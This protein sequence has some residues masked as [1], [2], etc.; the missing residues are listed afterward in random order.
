M[1]SA[2][3]LLTLNI[4]GIPIVHRDLPQRVE[5][6]G[7]ELKA[8]GYDIV[9]LQEA[10]RDKD[11]EALS[12]GS[13][14]AHLA[15]YERDV[16]LGTG[17]AILSRFPILQKF[18]RPFTAR[19]SALRIYQG[20][21]VANKGVLMAR[22]QTPGGELDVYDAHMISDYPAYRYR[23]LRLTQIFELAEAMD[24]WS[25]GRPVVLLT[26]LNA[27]PGDSEYEILKDLL[28]LDDVC[29]RRDEE[30]CPDP[31]RRTRIDHILMPLG[32]LKRTGKPAL[33]NDTP[34]RYSDHQGVSAEM[35]PK[36]LALRRKPNLR[37]R[38][39]ALEDIETAITAMLDAM[40]RR[41]RERA[42]IPAYGFLFALRYDHQASYLT[43]LRDRVHGQRLRAQKA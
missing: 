32:K 5:A 20:E 39:E 10:W 27:G 12:A 42:W 37:H 14:L 16:L 2:L 8:G 6:I 43:A 19:P 26:D 28:G 1:K 9:G 30:L 25:S 17:L 40:A 15:R 13:G 31:G 22:I 11:A 7:R 35:E 38:A 41:R 21:S 4:G 24:A 18:Q 36:A 23:T 33:V 34:Y 3:L 29:R